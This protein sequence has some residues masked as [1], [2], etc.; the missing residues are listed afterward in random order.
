LVVPRE[1]ERLERVRTVCAFLR[2]TVEAH[3]DLSLGKRQA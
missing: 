1:L 2:D 3:P